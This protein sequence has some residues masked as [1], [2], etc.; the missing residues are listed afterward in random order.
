MVS[1]VRAERKA[2]RFVKDKLD[3]DD[4]HHQLDS[5]RAYV[6]ELRQAWGKARA[7]NSAAPATSRQRL[8]MTLRRR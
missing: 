8:P 2:A 6:H 7:V 1:L 5:L 3:I 4:L